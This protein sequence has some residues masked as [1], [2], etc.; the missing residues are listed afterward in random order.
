MHVLHVAAGRVV[1]SE[2][3]EQGRDI[4]YTV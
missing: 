4:A 3:Y 2:T 1:A